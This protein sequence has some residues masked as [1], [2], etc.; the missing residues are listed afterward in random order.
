MR[1]SDHA[2][3]SESKPRL[4]LSAFR[5]RRGR[6]FSCRHLGRK[7]FDPLRDALPVIPHHDLDPVILPLSRNLNRRS[8]R[9]ILFRVIDQV[10]KR[11]H[12]ERP[13]DPDL[14]QVR[15]DIRLNGLPGIDAPKLSCGFRN[16]L[17]DI[18]LREVEFRVTGL[19]PRHFLQVPG[20]A[21]KQRGLPLN[22]GHRG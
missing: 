12:D 19:Q 2:H 8:L 13:V 17:R 1:L 7:G 21:A 16:E 9:G 14:R 4:P 18:C 10:L 20:K 6:G 5:R 15:R 11:P 22:R 3:Q